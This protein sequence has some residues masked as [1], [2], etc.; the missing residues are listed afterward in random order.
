MTGM[1]ERCGVQR[2]VFLVQV[3]NKK[4]AVVRKGIRVPQIQTQGI[5]QPNV[6][7]IRVLTL[8]SSVLLKRNPP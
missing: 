6:G 4:L 2:E 7:L 3:L 1:R 5:L 8:P